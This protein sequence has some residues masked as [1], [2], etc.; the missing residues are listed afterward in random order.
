MFVW[1]GLEEGYDTETE[2]CQTLGAELS[3][4][5]VELEGT[6]TELEVER[7]DHDDLRVAVG[8]VCDDLGMS[9]TEGVSSLAVWALGIRDRVREL[10]QTMLHFGV[11]YTLVAARSHY[12]QIDMA[13]LS[14]GITEDCPNEAMDEA[15]WEVAPLSAALAR[16]LEPS[17]I[18]TR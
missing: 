12:E 15:E 14:E 18:P 3:A 16:R 9:Q 10:A 8:V 11:N 2:K 17:V 4:V 13:A 6:K 5:R 7:S 1:P